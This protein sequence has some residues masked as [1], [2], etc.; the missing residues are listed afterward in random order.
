MWFGN[1][2]EI[3]LGPENPKLNYSSTAADPD[4]DG[5]YEPG[6]VGNEYLFA[7]TDSAKGKAL[8]KISLGRYDD[9]LP[10]TKMWVSEEYGSEIAALNDPSV[11]TGLQVYEMALPFDLTHCSVSQGLS[12][13]K[14]GKGGIPFTCAINA[15]CGDE[16]SQASLQ[17][18]QIGSGLFYRNP[19]EIFNSTK[20]ILEDS[21]WTCPGH[22]G[23]EHLK[24]CSAKAKCTLCDERY[25]DFGDHDY[26]L[27]INGNDFCVYCKQ[28]QVHVLDEDGHCKNCDYVQVKADEVLVGDLNGDGMVN[29]ADAALMNRYAAKW[30]IT[31]A[32]NA[33]KENYMDF[34]STFADTN[35]DG[36]MNS[37][38]A[39][40]M[41]RYAAKW[42]MPEGCRINTLVEVKR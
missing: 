23:G 26:S 17:G 28:C 42:I 13:E 37:A 38:D 3:T 4:F 19:P 35:G 32:V 24:N 25:G 15:Q 14:G 20:L 11:D 33:N 34:F 22:T 5:K 1:N 41:N 27:E 9:G 8:G 6:Y 16:Y 39:A 31:G 12:E 30:D 7:I 10:G 36:D 40:Q 2:V 21:L 18:F 29:S